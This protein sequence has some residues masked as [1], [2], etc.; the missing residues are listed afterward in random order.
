[1]QHHHLTL[2][3]LL[4]F[5]CSSSQEP[6]ADVGDAGPAVADA[7]ADTA[8]PLPPPATPDATPP[9]PPRPEARRLA[10]L[11]GPVLASPVVVPLFWGD[12]ADRAK[13]EALLG[14]L[15]GSDYWKLL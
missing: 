2:L 13:T 1:M 7:G 8:T 11:A 4:T 12:D 10:N 9:P 6:R 5:G 14:A 3:V 15:H